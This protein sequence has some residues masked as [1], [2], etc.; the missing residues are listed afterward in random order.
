MAVKT[1][2][3][4][5]GMRARCPGMNEPRGSSQSQ[6]FTLLSSGALSVGLQWS[7]NSSHVTE[8][9]VTWFQ[10][11]WLDPAVNIMSHLAQGTLSCKEPF[12]CASKSRETVLH[13]LTKNVV[14]SCVR[15]HAWRSVCVVEI[16]GRHADMATCRVVPRL[17]GR[18]PNSPLYL[19]TGRHGHVPKR[20]C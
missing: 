4:R 11:H 15:A 1:W 13:Q 7:P 12:E 18:A 6:S 17:E 3:A 9:L 5:S 10:V 20:S 2:L 19:I 16:S 14:N 8:D